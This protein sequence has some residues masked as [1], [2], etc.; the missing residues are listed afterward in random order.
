MPMVVQPLED[1]LAQEKSTMRADDLR[2]L[3]SGEVTADELQEENSL[4]SRTAK[5]RIINFHKYVARITARSQAEAAD[6][7]LRSHPQHAR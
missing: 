1:Y 7:S 2:R 4:W 6:L 5:S 3:K